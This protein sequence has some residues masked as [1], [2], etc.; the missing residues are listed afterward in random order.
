[1]KN[2]VSRALTRWLEPVN[3]IRKDVGSY[4]NGD[5]VNGAD[6][7]VPIKAVVQNANADDLILLPEG[8]RSSE[9]VKIHT[10]SEVKTVSEVGETEA[11][12]FDY[13]GSRYKIFDVANRKIGNYY[14]AIAI[15]IKV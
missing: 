15:R 2:D 7:S 6:I 9:S 10:V 14:K 4:V 8:S 1:M 12:Q 13:D 5:W 3:I 11:D